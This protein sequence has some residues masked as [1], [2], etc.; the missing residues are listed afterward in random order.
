M[1]KVLLALSFLMVFGLGS[2]LAQAQT[3]SGT[4][5]GSETE[6]PVPGVS[7]FV[8][9]TTIG[10]VTNVDGAYSLN[11]PEGSETLVFS[12]IGMETQEIAIEGQTTINVAMVDESIA[13]DEV[14]VTALGISRTKKSLGYAAQ[15]VDSEEIMAANNVNPMS[16]L[17]GKV[18]GLSIAG[19]NFAG[20]QNIMIRGGS[21]FSQSNQPLFVVDGV[22]IS[23]ENFNDTETQRG[24]G[25]YDY[26]SMTNDLNPYDIESIEVLKGS[27]AS[28]LYGS[29]GQNGVIMVTTKKGKK[30]TTDFSVEINSG[31][32]FEKVSILPKQQ[33]SYGG[34]YV[35]D[36]DTG[37]YDNDGFANATIDGQS[38]EI[39]DYG[40][41]ESWGPRFDPNRQVLHWWGLSDYEQ[42]ITSSPQ[43]GAWI[44]SPNDIEEFYETGVAYQNSVNITKSNENSSL[45]VGYTNVDMTGTV[46]NSEQTKNTFN[47]NGSI[48]LYEDIIELVSNLNYVRTDTKGRPQFGYGDNSQ[49]QKFF[50]WGQRQ[51]DMD[52]LANYVNPDGTQRVWNRRSFSNS[53]PL[54]S[55]NPYWTAYRNYQDDDRTRIYGK[56][57]I[58]VN[59][60]DYLH[61]SGN[62]YLDTYT[63]NQRER[64]AKGSQAL[65]MY[66]EITRQATEVNYEGKLDFNRN[67]GFFNILGM[68]G[69]NLRKEDYSR[70]EGETSGGLVVDNLYNLNNSAN[71]SVLD[72]YN[73]EK[74]IRSYFASASFGYKSFAY[75]DATYRKDFD[76]S[77]PSGVNDY[78]YSSVSGSLILSELLDVPQINNLKLRANYGETGNGTDPYQVYNTYTIG[79]PFNGTPQFTNSITLKN[80]FLKPEL[81]TEVEFGL[82]GV[83][84]GNRLGFDF[85]WYD[86]NTENQI[87]PIEV[88][89][90]SG[91]VEKVINA[92]TIQNTGVEL[93][94]YGTPVKTVDFSWDVSLNYANNKN[95]VL[96]LPEGLDKIQLMYTPFSGAYLNAV[97]GKTFQQL[98]AYD[99]IRDDNGNK[100]IDPS[101]GFY[102]TTGEL[103]DVGSVLPDYTMGL[104]NAFRYKNFDASFLI[105]A[106][107]GGN[108]YSLTHMWAMYSG[109]AEE[110]ATP[111]SN[112]NT[113]REDGIV[114]DGVLA[115][116]ST[117]AD[118]NVVLSNTR[119]ND[120]RISANDYGEYHYH[121]YGTPSAT[122]IFDA[123]YF[124]L[125]EVTI[126]YTLP[127][128][129]D[130]IESVRL[131]VYGRNLATWG[132]DNEGIDPETIV[133]GSGNIQGLEGGII[134]STKSYGFNIRIV[135]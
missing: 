96:D 94:L 51:L 7:V 58:R 12:F 98:Y 124:K 14:V 108:Y 32:S 93:L 100:V 36:P 47:I 81:T 79:T 3:I 66:K 104:R 85:S 44:A 92:G 39:V 34:G 18:A 97:E 103:N 114:L 68:V 23:N 115:D 64:V 19:Q 123:T 37:I 99:Y 35:Y 60:T 90:A 42:G 130:L 57:G 20:S 129:V 78:D 5:T 11:V 29:R 53:S 89:G 73:R 31:V 59:I 48:N 132:L 6:E 16:A 65:S 105:D 113:I 83:F 95:E 71:Q 106:S 40:M 75:I 112:G 43:T 74:E 56:T 26:G 21:S 107:V 88:S 61:A 101:T 22:P 69:A 4:V 131:S 63:F 121:G 30:G 54:Y 46:P 17:S 38:F 15:G 122:S 8:K 119:E 24:G 52:R 135:L 27:A 86:R 72:D 1:K 116:I 128:F 87:V 111:T 120:M 84:F 109:M 125:R 117:D 127:K 10:T 13:M 80:Q 118:G 28:A 33:N 9:G 2:L 77:L 82:E 62:V 102:A 45:R 134:P 70:L 49:S 55:D 67:F 76:S 41:D 25:G 133:G 50:Q 126:G 91:Y 110:T